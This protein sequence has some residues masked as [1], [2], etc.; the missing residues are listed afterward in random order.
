MRALAGV[1]DGMILSY[2]FVLEVRDRKKNVAFVSLGRKFR[3]ER[4]KVK[5]E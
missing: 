4:S 2:D 5:L 1:S 3:N